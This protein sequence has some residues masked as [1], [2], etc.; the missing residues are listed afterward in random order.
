MSRVKVI[1][2][3]LIRYPV[4]L[5]DEEADEFLFLDDFDNEEEANNFACEWAERL[6][7]LVTLL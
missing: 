1:V 4:Y 6:G 5:R 3:K 2:D 7:V